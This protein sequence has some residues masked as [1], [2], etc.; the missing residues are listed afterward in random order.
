MFGGPLRNKSEKYGL[1]VDLCGNSCHRLGPYSV[2]KNKETELDLK[3]WAQ[4]KCMEEQGWSK[5]DWHRVFG[6]NYL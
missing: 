4:K 1:V 3:R 6:K 2:H 5:K